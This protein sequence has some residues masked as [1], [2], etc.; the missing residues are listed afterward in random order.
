MLYQC[1]QFPK[2]NYVH[3]QKKHWIRNIDQVASIYV[4]NSMTI[5]LIMGNGSQSGGT[6][7]ITQNYGN[8]FD[9]S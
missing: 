1:V 8:K 7:Y 9:T 3:K 2:G 6:I 5:G 4:K